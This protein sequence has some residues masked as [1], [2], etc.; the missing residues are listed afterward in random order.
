MERLEYV[1]KQF[2]SLLYRVGVILPK[3][4]LFQWVGVILPKSTQDTAAQLTLGACGCN[5]PR[6]QRVLCCGHIVLLAEAKMED[7][8]L[9]TD[10]VHGHI[11]VK[12]AKFVSTSYK[13]TFD[14]NAK[15]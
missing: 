12:M 1:L 4:G 2:L 15:T 8:R 9:I 3:S 6:G 10:N 14:S 7:Y 11:K 13:T 5:I